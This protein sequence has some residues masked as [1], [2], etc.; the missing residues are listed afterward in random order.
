MPEGVTSVRFGPFELDADA[1][2]LRRAGVPLKLAPQPLRLLWLLVTHAGELVSRELIREQLWAGTTFVD[3]E[4][5]ENHCIRRIRLV[6]GDD[7]RRPRFVE[8]VP[9]RGYRFIAELESA[10]TPTATAGPASQLPPPLREPDRSGASL[11]LLP[12]GMIAAVG[13]SLGLALFWRAPRTS[14]PPSRRGLR[15]A[16]MPFADLSRSESLASGLVYEITTQLVRRRGAGLSVVAAPE[17]EADYW[18]EGSVQRSAGRVRVTAQLSE[19]GGNRVWAESYVRELSDEL[20]LQSELA[21]QIIRQLLAAMG[22][23]HPH[24]A[25]RDAASL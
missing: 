11:T 21:A 15:L 5:G 3:Y 8:T 19:A 14:R 7:A 4:Q 24:L 17:L 25:L 13:L 23:E 9:R 18:L 2:S 16:V 1:G 22:R 10:Q 6:L 20:A 12:L